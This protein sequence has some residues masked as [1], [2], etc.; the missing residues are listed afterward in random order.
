VSSWGDNYGNRVDRFNGGVAFVKDGG[1]ANGR[2]SIITQR[3]YYTR[4]TVSALTWRNGTL[5]VNWTFDSNGSGNST[6]AGQGCHSCMAGDTNNDG[7]QEIITGATTIASN[8]TLQCTTRKGHGDALHVGELV[9]GQGL[10]VFQ[11]HESGTYGH[12][13]H[14]ASTCSM[15]IDI[16]GSGDN[17]RGV[18]EYVASTDTTAA[19]CSSNVGS[20]NCQNGASVSSN[21]GSN[22]LIYWDADESREI[23]NGTSITKSGGGTLLSGSGVASCNGT[24]STPVL[25]ADLLGD[26]REEI[27]WKTSDNSA[28][29]IYTTTAVTTRRIYTLMH[30]PTYRAQVAFE[31]AS[32]NQPPHT[33]FKI[34]AGM[35]DPP[36]PDIYVK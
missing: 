32:Y 14:N 17:G 35:A 34:G 22:F 3:G 13:V 11:V 21:A 23:E 5:A 15:Y 9:A 31:N 2:P 18:A 20:M 28:L 16:T 24:K 36:K 1:A 10:S 27:I 12:D 7:A 30:D 4:L 26:W 33:G 6:A 29:R 25:T 8:G 19:T